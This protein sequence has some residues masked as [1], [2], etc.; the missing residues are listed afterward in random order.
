LKG[1]EGVGE[2]RRREN[3]RRAIERI[4]ALKE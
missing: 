4:S 1:K 2:L 3:A